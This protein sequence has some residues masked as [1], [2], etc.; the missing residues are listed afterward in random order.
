M[1]EQYLSLENRRRH[2]AARSEQSQSAAN[3]TLPLRLFR[4][5][6]PHCRPSTCLGMGLSEEGREGLERPAMGLPWKNCRRI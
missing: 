2:D 6:R 1:A 3:P 5:A 4:N